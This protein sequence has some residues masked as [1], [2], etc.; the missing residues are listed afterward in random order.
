MTDS[1]DKWLNAGDRYN[2]TFRTLGKCLNKTK[3]PLFYE[4]IIQAVLSASAR[5]SFMSAKKNF[6]YISR[7]HNPYL[8]LL[9]PH[10]IFI[11]YFSV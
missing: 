8:L 10:A 5:F 1:L 11:F 6:L 2:L 4:F 3:F 9:L 7:K